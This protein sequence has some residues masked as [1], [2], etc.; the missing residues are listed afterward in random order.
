MLNGLLNWNQIGYTM[1]N[2]ETVIVFNVLVSEY[3]STYPE[4]AEMSSKIAL[5]L[6][7]VCFQFVQGFLPI[8]FR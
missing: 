1:S 8:L 3:I 5:S 6:K 7:F 2:N 4:A